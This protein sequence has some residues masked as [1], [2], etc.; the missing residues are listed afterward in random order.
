MKEFWSTIFI[1]ANK[2][3][4]CLSDSRIYPNNFNLGPQKLIICSKNES[5]F[6]QIISFCGAD[7]C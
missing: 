3:K 2:S 6:E 7:L 5:F 1:L 4:N